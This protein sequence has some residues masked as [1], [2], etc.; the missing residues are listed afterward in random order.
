MKDDTSSLIVH[1]D[2]AS[3]FT[4]CTT[5]T[6]KSTKL[7]KTFFFD[8][9]LLSSPVYQRAV[10]ASFKHSR[11]RDKN[12]GPDSLKPQPISRNV[13]S[14]LQK[15]T[16]KGKARSIRIERSFLKNQESMRS[17]KEELEGK[18]RSM[19]I[20]RSPRENQESM[21]NAIKVLLMGGANSGKV[22]VLEQMKAT[23]GD[24][25]RE[26]LKF[27]RNEIILVVVDAMRTVL[28]YGEKTGLKMEDDESKKNVE[29]VLQQ[30]RY[31]FE[32]SLE[33]APAIESLWKNSKF[34]RFFDDCKEKLILTSALYF[35]DHVGRITAPSYSPTTADVLHIPTEHLG[36][37][38]HSYLIDNLV[39]QVYDVVTPPSNFKWL[40]VDITAIIFNVNLLS[41][42]L[43]SEKDPSENALRD[44]LTIFGRVVNG[45]WFRNTCVVLLFHHTNQFRAKLIERPFDR[46]F[47]DY[48]GG[49][50]FSNAKDY[51]LNRFRSVDQYADLKRIHAIFD[52]DESS[53]LDGVDSALRKFIR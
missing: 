43:A 33:L 18:T 23:L 36:I 25:D 51:L 35:F 28:E 30:S 4:A 3:G 34:A 19:Q 27:Y 40:H 10:R 11:R 7:S 8:A 24:Y 26:A 21:R 31:D 29:I 39:V 2:A 49:S 17:G 50:S 47:P 14:M 38:E 13:E 46:H 53:V 12:T 9:E 32:P 22:T 42:G 20:D 16:L 44:S 15:R 48:D 41:Y 5:S 52:D 6:G 37:K 1:R 45:M